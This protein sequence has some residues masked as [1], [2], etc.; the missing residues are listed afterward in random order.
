[1]LALG[2]NE[3]VVQGGDWGYGVRTLSFSHLGRNLR[4]YIG[5]SYDG[6]YVWSEAC[7]ILAY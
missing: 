2:Y 4:F 5:H 7:E 3:Y 6:G 1:M